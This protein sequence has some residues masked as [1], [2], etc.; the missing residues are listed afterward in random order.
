MR[1]IGGCRRFTGS[2]VMPLPPWIPFTYSSSAPGVLHIQLDTRLFTFASIV[3]TFTP[4]R[5]VLSVVGTVFPDVDFVALAALGHPAS[6]FRFRAPALPSPFYLPTRQLRRGPPVA[7]W[8]RTTLRGSPKD[9]PH[10]SGRS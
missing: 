7:Q 6:S 2:S 10:P 9:H 1:G 8:S 3:L 5:C 4:Q